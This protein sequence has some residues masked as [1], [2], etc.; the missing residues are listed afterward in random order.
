MYFVLWLVGSNITEFKVKSTKLVKYSGYSK[1]SRYTASSC[2]DLDNA[3]F[4]IGSKKN[5]D[6]R[7]YVVKTL[8]STVFWWSCLWLIKLLKLHEFWATRVFPF[9]KKRASQGLTVYDFTSFP[10][11][12]D[13]PY[14][15]ISDF[16]CSWHAWQ[17]PHSSGLTHQVSKI[18]VASTVWTVKIVK[19]LLLLYWENCVYFDGIH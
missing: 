11:K 9:P 17:A 5:W 1:A 2:T 10:W 6:E 16:A 15:H 18:Y 19:F 14:C 13:N 7:I 8:S 12:L 4:W 3:R